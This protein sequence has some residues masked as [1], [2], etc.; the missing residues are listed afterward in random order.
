MAKELSDT[1]RKQRKRGIIDLARP[2]AY[3]PWLTCRECIHGSGRRHSI[4]DLKYPT[5]TIHL[6]SDLE[7]RA[8]L[9]LRE[10]PRVQELFEQ[11]P[12]ELSTT[13]SICEELNTYHPSNPRTKDS[14]VMTTDF[15]A[16]VRVDKALI[17]KAYAVKPFCELEDRRVYSKLLIEKRYW[18]QK[19]IEWAVITEKNIDNT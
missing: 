7:L 19:G 16:Y 11:V 12:L 5:R 13:Q 9:M 2:E 6:M 3:L 10:N 15:V 1:A 4:P 17:P 8:Y 14:I 18:E